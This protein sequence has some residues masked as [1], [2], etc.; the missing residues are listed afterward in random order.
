MLPVIKAHAYGNDFL[1]VERRLTHARDQVS[2]SRALCD[3]HV[4]VGADGLIVYDRTARGAT[5]R[6]FNPDGSFS[7]VSGNGVRA[8]AA[9]LVDVHGFDPDDRTVVIGTDAGEKV[10]ALLGRD[11]PRLTFRA[12]MGHPEETSEVT[13]DV[14]GD[15]LRVVTLRVG[16]PQCVRLE[17]A[18][19][20]ERMHRLGPLLERHPHFPERTNVEFATVEAPDRVRN[21][22]LGARRRANPGIRNRRVRGRRGGRHLW[23][24]L[25]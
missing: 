23:R 20:V 6:L 4:G 11:G 10:L 2:L 9:V 15:P 12:A 24:R 25:P 13:L 5:M 22:D 21:P 7:E 1:Y 14:G 16:N 19:D 17:S 3:R 18:L 8:L